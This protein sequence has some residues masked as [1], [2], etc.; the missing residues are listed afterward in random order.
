MQRRKREI[1]DA[2]RA[3]LKTVAP[4]AKAILF[5]SRARGNS[6]KD[7]DWDILIL[8][9][10]DKIETSD[11]DNIAYPLFELGW[12]MDEQFS[13]KL[14]TFNEWHKRSFTL[15]YKNVEQEGIIL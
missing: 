3:K 11:Y 6:T 8:L 14:Y 7:S 5:G 4:N 12:Q 15:F 13:I 2:I 9:D 1:L 10:K